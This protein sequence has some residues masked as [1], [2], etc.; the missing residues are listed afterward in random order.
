MSTR[1]ITMRKLG[2]LLTLPTLLLA[3]PVAATDLSL[4]AGWQ[5]NRD[6]E[7]G[8]DPAPAAG[9]PGDE[10][11]IDSGAAYT[12]ALDFP[13]P[14]EADARLG[15]ML[16]HSAT[17]FDAVAGLADRDLTLTHLHFTG[18]R[19]YPRGRWEPFVMAGV[20]AAFVDPG[21]SSLDSTTRFSGHIAGG[22]NYRLG[23]S[24]LLR[25]EARWLATL[26]DGRGA[27]LCSGGCTVAFESDFYSQFQ[28]N[29]GLQ[30]RF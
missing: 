20:G 9:E 28:V 11:E 7:I 6:M 2:V 3:Q 12:L 27:A 8:D 19:Y 30:W 21:D 15:A 18:L 1:V 23:E 14:G 22:S 4:L 26:F 25:V 13:L 16:T 29:V 24:L 10:V 17:E 5:Y